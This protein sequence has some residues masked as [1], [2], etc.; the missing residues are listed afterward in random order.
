MLASATTPHNRPLAT[1]GLTKRIAN[2]ESAHAVAL[3]SMIEAWKNVYLD[4]DIHY[5]SHG[6]L[7]NPGSFFGKCLICM[8]PDYGTFSSA[9]RATYIQYSTCGKVVFRY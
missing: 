4:R 5:F 6:N 7:I 9:G 1:T 2:H 8:S 3:P